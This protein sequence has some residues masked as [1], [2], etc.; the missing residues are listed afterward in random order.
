MAVGGFMGSYRSGAP[1]QMKFLEA[2]VKEINKRETLCLRSARSQETTTDSVWKQST[3]HLNQL[4]EHDAR[5]SSIMSC[6]KLLALMMEHEIP[7]ANGCLVRSL[8]FPSAV[9]W[10]WE[11]SSRSCLTTALN[12]MSELPLN[13]RSK[14]GSQTLTHIFFLIN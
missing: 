6:W 12:L 13:S 2:G 10:W 7:A 3:S 11:R 5:R 8:Q 9:S 4:L 1:A 14:V